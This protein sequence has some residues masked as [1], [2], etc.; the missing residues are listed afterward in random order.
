MGD[1]D[2]KH[3]AN[4]INCRTSYKTAIV[5]ISLV[6]LAAMVLTFIGLGASKNKIK[7][8]SS[9]GFDITTPTPTSINTLL[10][11]GNTC[12]YN[13]HQPSSHVDSY[14]ECQ[15][16]C[17]LEQNCN[18]FTITKFRGQLVC[19]KLAQCQHPAPPCQ[20]FCQSGPKTCS[21]LLTQ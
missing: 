3:P 1:C 18:F 19:W 4:M 9:G 10:C 20:H 15:E 8:D 16:Q 11:L 17:S 14:E 21:F 7:S 13:D 6:I 12:P 2:T 5:L